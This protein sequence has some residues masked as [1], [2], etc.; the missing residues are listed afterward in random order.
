MNRGAGYGLE[1]PAGHSMRSFIIDEHHS[2]L[3][4]LAVNV[5]ER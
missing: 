3:E 5:V 2:G 4:M 1:N